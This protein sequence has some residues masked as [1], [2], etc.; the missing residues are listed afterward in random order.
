MED[1]E[2]NYY[3]EATQLSDAGDYSASIDICTEGIQHF[4]SWLSVRDT[5]SK[6]EVELFEFELYQLYSWRSTVNEFSHRYDAAISDITKVIEYYSTPGDRLL[7]YDNDDL[8]SDY[9][10]RAHLHFSIRAY[11]EAITDLNAAIGMNSNITDWYWLRARAKFNVGELE[12][13]IADAKRAREMAGSHSLLVDMIQKL[14]E[15]A[16][17]RL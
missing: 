16:Q 6:D 1:R 14:I 5:L 3:D 15:D 8:A 2:R 4:I 13:A 9:Y 10:Y 12:G 11:A 17:R 7:D